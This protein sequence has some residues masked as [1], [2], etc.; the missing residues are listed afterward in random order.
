MRSAS[1]RYVAVSAAVA[2]CSFT[3]LSRIARAA[4]VSD[5]DKK[6]VA[7]AGS[8]GLTEAKIGDYASTHGSNGVVKTFGQEMV[9]DHTSANKQLQDLCSQD[10]IDCPSSPNAMDQAEIDEVTKLNGPAFDKAYAADMVND[11]DKTIALFKK[12]ADDGTDPALKKF[13]SD[14]LPTLQHHLEM[15]QAMSTQVA[16]EK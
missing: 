13:A 5:T 7:D 12:E 16:D 4:D 1:I 2:A 6:F 8:G 3:H 11:H 9:T 15:A 14:T 10:G